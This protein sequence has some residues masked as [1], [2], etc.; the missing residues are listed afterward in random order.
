MLNA[1]RNFLVTRTGQ[2]VTVVLIAGAV[3]GLI[4]SLWFNVLADSAPVHFGNTQIFVCSET[5]K[6]FELE[7]KEGMTS[8]V[9]SPYSGKATG[10]PVDE[11]CTWTADGKVDDEPTYVLLNHKGPTFC[12]KCHRLVT[13]N[14]AVASADRQ[15]PSTEAEYQAMAKATGKKAQAGMEAMR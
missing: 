2:G 9:T 15:P 11:Q 13:G 3:F 8:P 4:Y 7:I 12:P 6:S 1:I 5:G 14:N 10:Y